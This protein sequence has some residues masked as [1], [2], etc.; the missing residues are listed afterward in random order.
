VGR[1]QG[2]PVVKVQVLRENQ[3]GGGSER[4]VGWGRI[5]GYD[6]DNGTV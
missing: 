4:D 3:E 1:W 6:D 2:N 5:V